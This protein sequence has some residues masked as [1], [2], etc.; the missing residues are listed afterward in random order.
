MRHPVVAIDGPAASGK[1]TTAR[2]AANGL[3][4]AHLNSGLL[5]R[6][7]TWM[8]LERGWGDSAPDF[9]T[10]V[11]GL[12]IQLVRT[13]GSLRVTVDGEDPGAALHAPRVTERVSAV[14]SVRAVREVA[15]THVRAAAQMRGLVCDGRDIG[16]KVFPDAEV[17]VF[18][19]ASARERARRRLLDLGEPPTEA[20]VDEEAVRLRARDRADSTRELSPLRR[21]PDAVEIDTTSLTVEEVVGQILV[22]CRDRGIRPEDAPEA[23]ALG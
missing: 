23:P 7:I 1:S 15:L 11:R 12:D 5:Y 10:N 9:E 19:V 3:G 22:L 13:P 16:T 8:A 17:K 2:R 14:S 20:R 4:F 18:L 21:A 6:A